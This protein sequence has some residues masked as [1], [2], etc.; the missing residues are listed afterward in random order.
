MPA[1]NFQAQF[2]EAVEYG[3]KL[4]T[5]RADRKD[6][7]PHAKRGDT[8]K[9]FTGM[10]SK[11]C[12]LLRTATVT[13]TARIRIKGTEMFLNNHRLP[14]IIYD[15]NCETTDDEFA[16]ADGFESFMDMADWFGRTHGLPFEGT[17]I[18]WSEA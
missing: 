14:S 1:F 11:A 18:Y 8:V 12:R 3:Y 2:A 9:L 4:Q 16:V 7:R 10:R 6:G 17:V 15:R 13:H 5:I